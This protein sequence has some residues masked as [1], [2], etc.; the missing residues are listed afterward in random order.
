[1]TTYAPKKAEIK[2][3]W[4]LVDAE[5]QVLGR[6]ATQIATVLRGKDKPTYAPY[7]DMGD[8]VI[9]VNAEKVKLTGKK[10]SDKVY[11]RHSGY[12]GGIKEVNA[13]ELLKKHPERVIE[14]A[15]KGMLP[16]NKLRKHILK[17]LK[18]YTGESHPHQAQ[19]PEPLQLE[20]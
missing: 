19:L 12:P 1:M 6:M 15:V 2:R 5:N 10:L 4:Y 8:F 16:R 17:K 11:Y 9:V 3:K 18:V 7:L 14:F 20:D 13:E